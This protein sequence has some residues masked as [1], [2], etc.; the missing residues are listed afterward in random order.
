MLCTLCVLLIALAASPAL[1]QE[2]DEGAANFVPLTNDLPFYEEDAGLSAFLNM[3]FGLSIGAAAILAVIMFSIGGFKYMTSEAFNTKSS[4]KEQMTS[5]VVGILIILAATIV[6]ETINPDI[7]SLRLFTPGNQRDIISGSAYDETLSG[8]AGAGGVVEV[9]RLGTCPTGISDPNAC[10]CDPPTPRAIEL[11][12]NVRRDGAG[13]PSSITCTFRIP[14]GSTGA[15]Q[16]LPEEPDEPDQSPTGDATDTGVA[17]G[18]I[19]PP[20]PAPPK[21]PVPGGNDGEVEAGSG[22]IAPPP[23]PPPPPKPQGTNQ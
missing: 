7:V 13:N 11:E 14:A 19:N 6:L 21:P 10:F 18:A 17:P 16:N 1:A 3:L 5:A 8:N 9:T 2:A 4:A 12:R 23:P 20:P 22:D 15:P